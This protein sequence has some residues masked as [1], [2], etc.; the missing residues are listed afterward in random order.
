MLLFKNAKFVKKTLLQFT[1]RID[2]IDNESSP[3]TLKNR[4]PNNFKSFKNHPFVV[5]SSSFAAK[6]KNFQ[7]THTHRQF[8]VK[9]K[10]CPN[11]KKL[12][13]SEPSNIELWLK[14]LS[15]TYF[16]QNYFG[17]WVIEVQV[18]VKSILFAF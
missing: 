9:Q 15:I 6:S 2:D 10:I 8:N 12:T 17:E 1:F 16:A 11:Q 5:G 13:K 14:K 7:L 4:L 3:Q 18:K